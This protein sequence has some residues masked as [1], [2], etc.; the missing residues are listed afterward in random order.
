MR[1]CCT[2]LLTVLLG[3]GTLA[4]YAGGKQEPG[5]M[6]AEEVEL[7]PIKIAA[8]SA[9]DHVTNFA[10]LDLGIFEKYGLDAEITVYD[11][12]VQIVN[13]LVSGDADVGTFGSV[14]M[15][16]SISNDI[17]LKLIAYNH[18]DPN[19]KWYNDNQTIVASASS[20]V[21]EGDYASLRGKKIGL[22]V[23]TATEPYLFGL[24]DSVGVDQG[25]IEI[26]NIAPPD[27]AIALKQGS[28]D[29]AVIWEAFA[30]TILHEVDGSVL[31]ARG[32]SPGW[33]DPGTVVTHTRTLNTKRENLKRYLVA[34]AESHKW[35]RNNLDEAAEIAT[36][37]ITGLDLEIAKSSIRAPRLDVRMSK[38]TIQGYDEITIPYLYSKGKLAKI[39]PAEIVV[40]PSL[41]VEVMNEY[42]DLFSDQ[43]PIP[44]QYRLK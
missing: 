17:P 20:G 14:P 34:Q 27:L 3:F 28:I 39:I 23:G 36:R 9:I 21:K 43:E 8:G 13:A 19:R 30:S 11:T 15:L 18:G 38:L 22:P 2:I 4:L 41:I 37:W 40:E 7:L 1:K 16:S 31:V 35:V 6:A 25:S 44:S 10:A 5:V 24:L 32:Q 12:G 29:V 42:P 33:F 26:V